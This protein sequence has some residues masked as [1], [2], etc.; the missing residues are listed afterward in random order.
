MP[1]V[2]AIVVGR[3]LPDFVQNPLALRRSQNSSSLISARR[4]EDNWIVTKRR[5]MCQMAKW[6]RSRW[7]RPALGPHSWHP[8]ARGRAGSNVALLSHNELFGALILTPSP[9]SCVRNSH[10]N[11]TALGSFFRIMEQCIRSR[12]RNQP[13]VIQV[14]AIGENFARD[15]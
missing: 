14:I 10:A 7:R 13:S 5:H 3:A 6:G 11:P 4:K 1:Y 8:A 9:S 12:A 15:L 2:P